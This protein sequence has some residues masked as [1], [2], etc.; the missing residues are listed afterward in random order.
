MKLPN[1]LTKKDLSFIGFIVAYILLGLGIYFYFGNRPEQTPVQPQTNK[2]LPQTETKDFT[3][4]VFGD[5]GVGS[6]EQKQ[7]A[8]LL[9]KKRAD[10]ILHTGDL[11]YQRGSYEEIQKNVL[12][13][14]QDIFAN[15]AFYPSLGNHDYG[16]D[17]GQPF[18]DT[19]KLPGNER[20]YYFEYKDTLFIALDTNDPLNQNP[21]QM[22]TWLE[23]TLA[24]SDSDWVI[25][26]FHH[27]AYSTG[28]HG[29]DGRVQEKVVPLLEKY[30]VD[31][32]FSGHDHNYQR[33]CPIKNNS[34]Q[35]SGVT[36]IVTGG[37]GAPLYPVGKE[38]WFTA[39]QISAHQFVLAEKKNCT[40]TFKVIGLEE[41]Q[42]DQFS[43]SK[44][45]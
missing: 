6:S 19:F 42:I 16:T 8:Q 5:S 34:C 24:E 43:K 39:K 26:Y 45:S 25:V 4:L 30:N 1:S 23:K 20:Y 2:S 7:I 11:A 22:L 14:Y 35:S 18:V 15:S 44:C 10:L 17:K 3:F 21:N 38:Q 9:K 29:S 12:E 36:Y 32:V 41:A 40:L 27:P 13:I 37:G 28:L 31:F 33:T